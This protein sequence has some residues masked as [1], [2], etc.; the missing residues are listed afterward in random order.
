MTTRPTSAKVREALFSIL[1]AIDGAHVL[2]LYAGSGAL[3]IEAL[4][5]GAESAVFVE[6]DR[7]AL[8]CIRE[9]LAEVGAASRARVVPTSVPRSVAA[10]ESRG[11]DL[12]LCDPPWEALE[13][14][15]EALEELVSSERLG[16]AARVVLEHS[17]RDA[18]PDV[19]RL[20]AYDR[21]RWGDT[22]VSFFRAT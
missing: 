7:A 20:V 19:P 14:A 13:G 17:A 3:G 6:H 15:I 12:V 18:E 16:A 4:S 2:D 9:N 8:A 10:L 21:R 11:F 5:R 22:A 1:G